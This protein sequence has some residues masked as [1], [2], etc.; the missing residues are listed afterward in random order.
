MNLAA[1]EG[2][3]VQC[4]CSTRGTHRITLVIN[5]VISHEL[6]KAVKCLRQVEHIHGHL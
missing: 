2:Y 5:P 6:G 1:P 4:T 3:A